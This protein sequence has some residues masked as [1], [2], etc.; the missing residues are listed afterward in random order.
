MV[1]VGAVTVTFANIFNGAIAKRKTTTLTKS[2]IALLLN[3]EIFK[4][5]ALKNDPLLAEKKDCKDV[6]IR[7]VL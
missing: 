3:V 7:L 1:S 6:S 4:K 5:A 2:V